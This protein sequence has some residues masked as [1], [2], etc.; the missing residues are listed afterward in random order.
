MTSET[1][2]LAACFNCVCERF[3]S[4]DN[5]QFY[6][7][8]HSGFNPGFQLLACIPGQRSIPVSYRKSKIKDSNDKK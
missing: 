5:V 8:C 3:Y 2:H 6:K 4:K 7:A 1:A